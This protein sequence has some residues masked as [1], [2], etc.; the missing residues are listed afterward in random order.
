MQNIGLFGSSFNPPHCG[1]F[2]VLKDLM[3]RQAFDEIWLLP[4]YQHP[5]GKDLLAYE[6]RLQLLNLLLKDLHEPRLKI[7]TIEKELDRKPSYMF[8]TIT[9]LQKR[10]PKACFSLIVGSDVKNELHKWY[11]SEDL[12]KKVNFYFIPRA[13]VET[14]PYPE[15]SSSLIRQ[16]LKNKQS[17]AGL[18]TKAIENHIHQHGLYT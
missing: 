12:Q 1:H 4:V 11:R 5:F 2:A 18:T 16:K 7:C 6:K 10:H 3:D 9:E 14:S 17:I 15:V 13:G 8:D